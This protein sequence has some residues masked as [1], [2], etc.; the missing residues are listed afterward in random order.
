MKISTEIGSVKNFCGEEKAVEL[1][2]RAGFDA[3]DFSLFNMIDYDWGT[4]VM[5]DGNPRFAAGNYLAFA[6]RL[7]QIGLDNGITCNQSH[8]PFPNLGLPEMKDYFKRS[9]E[10]TAE[11]GGNI[12]IIHPMNEESAEKNAEIY[13]EL[14]P[15][16]KENGVMIAAEN[17]WCWDDEN[18]HA[19]AAACSDPE[20]FNAHLDAVN[21]PFFVACLDLGHAEMFGLGTSAAEMIRALGPRL[22]ALHVHDND[23]K[24]DSHWLPGYGKMDFDAVLRALKDVQYDGYLTLESDRHLE[25]YNENNYVDGVMEMGRVARR[26]AD[27]FESLGQVC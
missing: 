17:M 14:L 1:C 7:R 24:Y 26:L 19:S 6:R 18:D 13:N 27:K 2:A 10:C 3:W 4:G 22:K 15:I 12:C 20:S 11:A 25:R 9:L 16:A 23:L 21:D 5:K 8:A